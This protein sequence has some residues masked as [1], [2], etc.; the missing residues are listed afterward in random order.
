MLKY[1]AGDP[2]AFKNVKS[3]YLLYDEL[4]GANIEGGGRI[5][6]A[7]KDGKF[8]IPDDADKGLIY[9][10]LDKNFNVVTDPIFH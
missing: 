10:G 8:S 9:I 5:I 6:I 2:E 4:D 1:D 3:D 7:T